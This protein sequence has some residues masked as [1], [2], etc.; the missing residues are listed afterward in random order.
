MQR[1]LQ[2]LLGGMGCVFGVLQL[3]LASLGRVQHL[4]K[5]CGLLSGSL[6]QLGQRDGVLPIVVC[7]HGC[8]GLAQFIPL[9]LPLGD[10]CR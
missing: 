7:Q 8:I 10:Y 4:L 6:L 9:L 2:C 5:L 1:V 3:A